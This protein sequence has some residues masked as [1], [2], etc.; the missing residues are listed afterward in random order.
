MLLNTISDAP[1]TDLQKEDLNTVYRSGMHAL[2]LMNGLIDIARINR[3][4][5]ELNP[6]D[7]NIIQL[8]EQS[9]AQWKKFNPGTDVQ[10]DYQ[11]LTP[12]TTIR[13]DEQLIR[14]VI[15]GFVAYVAQYCEART[16]V[17]VT[18]EEE[19][20]LLLFTFT[21]TGMKTRQPSDLDLEMLGYV[22]RTFVEMHKGKIRQAEETDEGAI[23]RFV[24]PKG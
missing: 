2:T 10:T 22:N 4:E 16:K 9:L 6:K 24:L 20:D 7:T 19:P 8:I 14:Q 17:T 21:S 1:L 18:V 11:V 3:H 13:A 15:S 5:K 12:A 23:V